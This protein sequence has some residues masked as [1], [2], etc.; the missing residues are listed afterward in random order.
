MPMFL[1]EGR[2]ATAGTG[3]R[4]FEAG[5]PA[6][7]FLHG[8][9]MDHTVWQFPARYFAH[10]GRAVLAP[11]LPG[12][13]ASAGPALESVPAMAAW[14][15][16][17]LAALGLESAALVGH[18][19]GAAIAL[20][21]AARSPRVARLALLGAA[22]RMPVHPELLA[23]ARGDQP[24]AADLVASWGHGAIGRMGGGPTPGLWL[25]DG[26]RRLLDRAPPQVLATDLAACDGFDAAAL[27]GEIRCPTLVLAGAEDRMTPAREGRRLAALIAGAELRELAGVGHMLMTER[28]DRVID[29]LKGW[30]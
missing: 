25:M 19:M 16:A 7:V 2:E 5:R 9:G 27:A 23:A 30:L 13:G 1:V 10:R 21:T 6:I 11:D 29:A 24:L 12:H 15:E 20:A 18:S 4:P 28:P 26:A 3:G 22:P 8:A 17:L 14:V